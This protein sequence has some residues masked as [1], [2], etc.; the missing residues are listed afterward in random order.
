MSRAGGG[1]VL[2]EASPSLDVIEVSLTSFVRDSEDRHSHRYLHRHRRHPNPGQRLDEELTSDSPAATMSV[3]TERTRSPSLFVRDSPSDHGPG[4]SVRPVQTERRSR[5]TH[6]HHHHHHHHHSHTHRG[7][8]HHHHHH[9]RPSARRPQ[10]QPQPAAPASF[11]DLTEEPDDPVETQL[12]SQQPSQNSQASS[13]PRR[14]SQRASTPPRLTRSDGPISRV[15]MPELIDLTGDSPEAEHPRPQ[16]RGRPPLA[17]PRHPHDQLPPPRGDALFQVGFGGGISGFNL[18]RSLINPSGRFG[19]ILQGIGGL[20]DLDVTRTA[21]RA[22]PERTSPKIP[23]A[24]TPPTRS[25]FVRNT[26]VEPE[27]ELTMI[28]PCCE[29][30]L[31]YD[32]NYSAPDSSSGGSRK[33]KRAVGEHHFWA[34]KEC[35]HVYCSDCFD[36]RMPTKSNPKGA[37][38]PSRNQKDIRCIVEDCE[39]KVSNKSHWVGLFASG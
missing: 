29:E 8:H 28:C 33:R 39:S 16:R 38:F 5:R 32:R 11:I 3:V 14:T 19:A 18:A 31:A 12:R 2:T 37:G 22:E 26:C 35:G 27:E 6:S 36:K 10:P 30:E 13:N 21:R 20:Y 23:R 17:L 9:A 7:V 15:N 24:P 1:Q 4:P 25:G 34:V